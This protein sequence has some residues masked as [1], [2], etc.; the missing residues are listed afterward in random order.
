M[1][2]IEISNI[3]ADCGKFIINTLLTEIFN[4]FVDG[5][6]LITR[7]INNNNILSRDDLVII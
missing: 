7:S 1:Y 3:L 4:V 2:F 5:I 6:N